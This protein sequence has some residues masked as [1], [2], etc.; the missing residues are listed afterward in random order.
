M[1]SIP[2]PYWI[3]HQLLTFHLVDLLVYAAPA[4]ADTYVSRAYR[5]QLKLGLFLRQTQSA[6][7]RRLLTGAAW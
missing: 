5:L 3:H 6:R 1:S 7:G 4:C 2:Y